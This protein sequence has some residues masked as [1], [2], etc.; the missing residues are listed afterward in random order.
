MS[1]MEPVSPYQLHLGGNLA[2]IP[3]SKE[4]EG[5]LASLSWFHFCTLAPCSH[6]FNST[7]LNTSTPYTVYNVSMYSSQSEHCEI[8]SV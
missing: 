3:Q 7:T 4:T 5:G 1:E 8:R 6:Q 2:Y